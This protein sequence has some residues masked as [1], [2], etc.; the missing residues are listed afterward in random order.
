MTVDPYEL[1][2]LA[3]LPEHLDVLKRMRIESKE[4]MIATRDLG[5][6]P[7]MDM[8]V[9]CDSDGDANRILAG[10]SGRKRLERI[11]T[12]AD[13]ATAGDRKAVLSA[14]NDKDYVVRYWG[15]IG[16]GL[17]PREADY[18][19]LMSLLQDRSF[20]VRIVAAQALLNPLQSQP[21]P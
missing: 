5:L 20:S 19:Q 16:L 4:W 11:I 2:N 15:C 9:E 3:S 14:L 8:I 7:E 17:L 13:A 1:N 12:A 6:M 18:H 21:Y 10:D